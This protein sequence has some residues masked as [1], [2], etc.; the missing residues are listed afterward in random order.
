VVLAPAE[1]RFLAGHAGFGAV[2][3]VDADVDI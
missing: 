3:P 1:G 2:N